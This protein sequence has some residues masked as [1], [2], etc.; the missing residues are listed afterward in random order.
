MTIA[1]VFKSI[2]FDSFFDKRIDEINIKKVNS[3][4]K[5]V[6]LRKR[7]LNFG[8]IDNLLISRL[9]EFIITYDSLY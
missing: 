1:S 3:K 7:F 9:L 2:F 6:I 4:V 5:G 8:R